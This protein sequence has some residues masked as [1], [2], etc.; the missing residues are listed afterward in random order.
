MAHPAIQVLYIAMPAVYDGSGTYDEGAYLRDMV[1]H[2]LRTILGVRAATHNPVAECSFMGTAVPVHTS[3]LRR[4]CGLHFTWS[5]HM[6]PVKH[7]NA[8]SVMMPSG[9][10][11]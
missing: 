9:Q 5:P 3:H 2:G 7:L 11:G 1:F 6:S 8:E 10:R 4:D